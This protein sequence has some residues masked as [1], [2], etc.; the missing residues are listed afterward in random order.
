MK[1][2]IKYIK[3]NVKREYKELSIKDITSVIII[4][5]IVGCILGLFLNTFIIDCLILIAL[6]LFLYVIWDDAVNYC[7]NRDLITELQEIKT[8]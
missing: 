8:K 5:S 1:C 4:P 2:E 7:N 3:H 6:M